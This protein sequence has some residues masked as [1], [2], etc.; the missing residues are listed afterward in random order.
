[1]PWVEVFTVLVI[2]HL[3]G[4]FLLQTEWQATNKHGG[5]GGDPVKRRA[6]I[7]HILTYA[8]PFVP[9]FIW[10]ADEETAGNAIAAAVIVLGT[11]LVQ[12]DGRA[13]TW[14]VLRVKKTSAAFGS[15]LWVAI[16]QSL[17]IAWL[18]AAALVAVA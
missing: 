18:F 5:L 12:D 17:H 15:V 16:D 4:D 13:L 1:M 9:A 11:H 7:M 14:Y 10:V 2:A 6:L 8:I 3:V